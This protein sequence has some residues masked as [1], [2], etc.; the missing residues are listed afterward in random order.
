MKKALSS[1]AVIPSEEFYDQVGIQYEEAF[2]HDVGLHRIIQRFLELLPGDARVLDCGCGTGKPV[3]HMI[4]ES[5]R[6]V[7]GIDLSRKMVE[8][9]SKQVPTGSF[10]KS[11]MLHYDPTDHLNGIIAMLSL[12][13]LT[14]EEISSMAAKWFD[15]L[16][17]NG[18]LLIGVF[19][20]EDCDTT[21]EMYDPDGQCA[22][23]I[24]FTFMNHKVSM[25]LF[26]KA[27]WNAL[28]V[29][30]GF[31]LVHAE[32]DVFRPPA[33][34]VCDDEPHYFVIAQKPSTA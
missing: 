6:K 34:T 14:R 3:A 9:S 2:G 15:W 22:T 8:L 7:N 20:A 23:G 25:T 21:P 13:E 29:D 24:P 11:N 4:A 28:L 18:S 30:A 26:T 10:K 19:G 33:S 32:T 27:G 31:E 12:F 1:K 16:Q 5:G 17:P